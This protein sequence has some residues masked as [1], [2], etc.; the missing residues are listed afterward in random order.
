MP[1]E[2]LFQPGIQ[3]AADPAVVLLTAIFVICLRIAA[4]GTSSTASSHENQPATASYVFNIDNLLD[5]DALKKQQVV[6]AL[7]NSSNGSECTV[8]P[9]TNMDSRRLLTPEQQQ[10]TS[11]G[12]AS[13]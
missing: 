7:F 6:V 11:S 2:V 3:P 8:L 1:V 9:S 5:L 12:L 13:A 4:P 10:T